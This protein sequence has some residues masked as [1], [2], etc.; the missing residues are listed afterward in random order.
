[1][2]AKNRLI[3][4]GEMTGESSPASRRAV[5]SR[6]APRSGV[7]PFTPAPATACRGGRSGCQ[8]RRGLHF[9]EP[10][11]RH[12]KW[13]LLPVLTV[14]EFEREGAAEADLAQDAE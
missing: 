9:F 3:F 10:R 2:I 5:P 11:F 8:P 14:E 6:C 12:E 7:S 4:N 13:V 1:S